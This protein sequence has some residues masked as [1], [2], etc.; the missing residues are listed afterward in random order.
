MHIIDKNIVDLGEVYNTR[1][2]NRKYLIPWLSNKLGISDNYVIVNDNLYTRKLPE[3]KH[4]DTIVL[5]LSHNPVDSVDHQ[6][7]VQAF[8]KKHSSKKVIVLSDDANEKYY[9]SYFHLRYSLSIYPFEEKPI[10]HKFSC[11]NSVPKI[12]RLITLNKIYQHNLQDSVLHSFL[13]N[14][15]KHTKNHLESDYWKQ[16]IKNYADEYNYFSNTLKHICPITIDDN[17]D[18]NPYLN[19]HTV[20]SPAYNQTALHVI[21]ESS[22][23]RLFFTE[24]TWKPIYAKQLFL[25][26]NAPGSIKKLEHFGFDVFRDFIDH[27]YD[28]EQGLVKRITMCVKEI[29][30]LKDNIMDIY[31]CTA[32]RR[33]ANLLHLQSDE[34]RNL[35]EISI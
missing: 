34:F 8:I 10:I 3:L 19:D 22:F 16:D 7:M 27:S 32:Q 33:A 12:H 29:E 9:T 4:F 28:E 31:Q 35:V 14:K 24:K 15:Q 25:S 21:T 1:T 17:A 11:L 13:W 30:R 18:R 2:V 26:I 23:T 6:E 5:D 20:S